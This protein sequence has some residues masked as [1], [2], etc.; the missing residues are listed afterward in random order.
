MFFFVLL[1]LLWQNFLP[2]LILFLLDSIRHVPFVFR[3]LTL[4]LLFVL[5]SLCNNCCELG[6]EHELPFELVDGGSHRDGFVAIK[7]LGSPRAL[8]A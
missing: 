4:L 2:H 1:P 5:V 7:G 3:C 8:V 6:Q